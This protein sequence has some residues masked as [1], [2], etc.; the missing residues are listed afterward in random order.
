MIADVKALIGAI[1]PALK[2]VLIVGPVQGR[3]ARPLAPTP[4]AHRARLADVRDRYCDRC[5]CDGV[6]VGAWRSG[7]PGDRERDVCTRK[8]RR[9]CALGTG[10][11]GSGVLAVPMRGMF[12]TDTTALRT[13]IPCDWAL[14][15]SDA[16]AYL[17]GATW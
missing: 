8:T 9:R 14:R 12:Q 16:V 3:I 1:A 10:A 7:F 2:P 4:V 13:I 17:T 5:R 6:C 15:R 11:Q